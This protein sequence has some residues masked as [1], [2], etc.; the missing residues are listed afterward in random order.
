MIKREI[1]NEILILTIDRPKAMNAINQQVMD[2]LKEVF[3]DNKQETLKNRGVIITGCGDKA[4]VAGADITEFPEYGEKEGAALAQKGHDVFDA[5]EQ[6]TIP[7]I[8]AIN[9][10]S[11][12]GGNELAMACHMRIAEEHARFGQPEINLGLIPGYGGTQRLI[13]YIGKPKAVELLLTGDMLSAEEALKLH[14]VNK[15]VNK[16]ESMPEAFRLLEKIA[17]KSA[18]TVN[19]MLQAVSAYHQHEQAYDKEVELFG[20][21]FELED[22]K[23]GVR[24]FMEKRKPKFTGS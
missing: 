15:V 20:E 11:L 3:I 23:E 9:G 22:M 13:R 14:L 21:C 8:A 18:A 17:E 24:A 1:Q 19:K 7:V 12:G 6:F 4:F 5:I 16:G 2:D 10:F